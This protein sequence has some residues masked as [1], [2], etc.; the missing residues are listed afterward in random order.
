M[1][2]NIKMPKALACAQT[3]S[4]LSLVPN[5]VVYSHKAFLKAASHPGP[6]GPI[7]STLFLEAPLENVIWRD[8][9][10]CLFFS[11]KN[12]YF[13]SLLAARYSFKNVYL[14]LD[15]RKRIF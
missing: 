2:L 5:K 10:D 3:E 4:N 14:L 13:C 15:M 9:Y 8:D 7:G 11:F 6:T 1:V 12:M